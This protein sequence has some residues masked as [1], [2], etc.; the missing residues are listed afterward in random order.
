[1]ASKSNSIDMTSKQAELANWLE[2]NQKDYRLLELDESGY[3]HFE[4]IGD[5]KS[6]ATVWDAHLYSLEYLKEQTR[7]FIEVSQEAA[8]DRRKIVIGLPLPVID[9]SAVEKTII[10]IRQYKRLHSGRHEFGGE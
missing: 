8:E 7:S 10:M 1:M 2:Q 5:F 4:F 9:I 6:Q 3:A